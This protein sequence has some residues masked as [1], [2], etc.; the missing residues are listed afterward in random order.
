MCTS[1]CVRLAPS[2]SWENLFEGAND[3]YPHDHY[4]VSS[5]R[6]EGIN[7]VNKKGL[8]TLRPLS[9]F[10]KDLVLSSSPVVNVQINRH[11]LSLAKKASE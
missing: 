4:G 9:D 10:S 6:K 2:Q 1:V 7:R 5:L 8:H 3:R 11:M